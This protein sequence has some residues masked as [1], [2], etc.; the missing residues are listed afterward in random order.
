[1]SKENR[2]Q[3]YRIKE[4]ERKVKGLQQQVGIINSVSN[5]RHKSAEKRI[6]D[7]EIKDAVARGAPQKDVAK[8]FC[9]SAGRVSQIVKKVA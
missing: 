3:T 4:L 7:L 1:M 9:I 8:I 5:A 2:E 6:R